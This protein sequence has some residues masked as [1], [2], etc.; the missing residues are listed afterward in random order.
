[1]RP[2]ADLIE[3]VRREYSVAAAELEE[4]VGFLGGCGFEDV[5]VLNNELVLF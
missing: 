5:Q 2:G 4:F 3:V 1:V